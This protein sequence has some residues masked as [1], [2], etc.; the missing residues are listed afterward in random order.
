MDMLDIIDENG[1]VIDT[2]PFAE[3]HKRQL[4]HRFVRVFVVNAQGNYV[5]HK[6]DA[7]IL[8]GGL[9]DTAG[10]H[11]DSGEDFLDA[12]VREVAEEMGISISKDD[13][14]YIGPISDRSRPEKENMVGELYRVQ[15]N[16]PYKA[17]M[18]EVSSFVTVPESAL[19]TAGGLSSYG[20]VSLKL[21]T[22]IDAISDGGGFI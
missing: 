14:N 2:V 16:G 6:R 1:A 9:L 4:L 19:L 3:A 18:G 13:L 21:Q 11:L 20:E 8:D 15:H 22:C 17:E 12:A 7:S 5:L 10:G